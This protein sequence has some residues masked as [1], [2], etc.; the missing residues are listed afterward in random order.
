VED[1]QELRYTETIVKE[2]M[3]LY[4][5]AYVIGRQAVKPCTLGRHSIAAGTTV[6]IS[7][8]VLHRDPRFFEEP[9]RFRPERWAG[10]AARR[11][12]RNVYLPFGG[13]PR[14]CIGAGFAMMEATMLLA[15][16]GR[17]WTFR[18]ASDRPVT[19]FPS[20]TLR[21]Q[22][23]VWGTVARRTPDRTR[24]ASAIRANARAGSPPGEAARETASS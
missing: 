20:I 21:P 14:V 24:A 3:R 22:S 11:L 8:W 18:L 15:A 1:L 6:F 23:G 17:R 10:D 16:I 13:G 9:E 12:P 4:P 5:P 19:L 7:P 2:A